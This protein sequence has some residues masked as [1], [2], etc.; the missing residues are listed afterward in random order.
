MRMLR[1]FEMKKALAFPVNVLKSRVYIPSH[2][3]VV[4][5]D[6]F[7]LHSKVDENIEHLQCAI[8]WLTTAQ[9]VNQDGGVSAGYSFSRGWNPSYSETTGYIIPTMFD[10]YHLTGDN[11]YEQRAIKMTDWEIHAQMKSGAVQS[12]HLGVLPKKPAVFNT[13]Q[14]LFGLVRTYKE[15]KKDKYK[16]AA[17]K[18]ANWLV[19]SQDE[20]GTWRAGLSTLASNPV[21]TYNTRTAWGLLQVH[22]ITSQENYLIAAKKNID[23]SL[24]QQL[25]NGWFKNNAFNIN[26]DPLLHTIAYAIR[27]VL[28]CGIYLDN[29][30]YIDAAKKSA[31]ALL[32]LQQKDGSLFGEYNFKWKNTVNYSCLTGDAQVSIIWLRL[33]EMTQNKKYL[34]AAKKMNYYLKTTQDLNSNNKCIRGGIKG[35]QPIYGGYMSFTYPNWAAKFFVDALLLEDKIEKQIG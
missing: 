16:K 33:F 31:D 20:D 32:K 30:T 19:E 17:E 35:S 9:D 18:A 27:G 2:F 28:E 3:K 26:E 1:L 24:T 10:Y 22:N 23:W 7:N 12:G 11:E 8:D 34:S 25:N 15:T 14:V 4:L 6:L 21:H 5:D 13:G 29:K